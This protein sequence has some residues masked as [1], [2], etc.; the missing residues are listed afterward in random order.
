MQI[1]DLL[2][3][4]QVI[5]QLLNRRMPAK[6]ARKWSKLTYALVKNQR[7]IEQELETVDKARVKLLSANW[8]KDEKTNHYDI[9]DE[10]LPKWNAM[11]EELLSG[12]ADFT[13]YQV[14]FALIE[15][16]EI[17]PGEMFGI[18]FLFT[19]AETDP[20]A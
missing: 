16:I 19:D 3:A 12:E 18:S 6:E 17:T 10:D 4:Q 13:P 9:P 5:Q 7:L 1:K 20:A 11:Y 14:P 2:L 15:N 8:T